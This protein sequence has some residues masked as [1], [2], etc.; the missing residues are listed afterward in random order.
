MYFGYRND[1]DFR[2][3]LLPEPCVYGSSTEILIHQ[4]YVLLNI[5][6]VSYYMSIYIHVYIDN[7]LV[8]D[9]IYR[10]FILHA[11]H[12]W[13][14]MSDVDPTCQVLTLHVSCWLYMSGV[15]PTCQVLTLQ[16]RCWPYMYGVDPTCQVLT[17]YVRC[18]PYMSG[19]AIRPKCHVLNLHACQVSFSLIINTIQRIWNS[20]GKQW[21]VFILL[22]II[23]V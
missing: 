11:W 23:I 18:W 8:I 13:G 16:V 9:P 4:N 6:T 15:D 19:V 14:Y 1:N 10:V 21:S 2:R 12:V 5:R 22:S 3:T 20:A 7:H 17:L